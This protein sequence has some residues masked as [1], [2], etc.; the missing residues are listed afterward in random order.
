MGV[1][2]SLW[3]LGWRKYTGRSASHLMRKVVWISLAYGSLRSFPAFRFFGGK[4]IGIDFRAENELLVSRNLLPL[5][6]CFFDVC[7][8]VVE[9]I[10]HVLVKCTVANQVWMVGLP[11]L[12]EL[13]LWT[14]RGIGCLPYWEYLTFSLHQTDR[15]RGNPI[16]R[17][18]LPYYQ[19]APTGDELLLTSSFGL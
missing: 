4:L 5:S 15:Q 3:R 9:D 16:E 13:E 17:L 8:G 7:E 11:E 2:C 1:F 19:Q 10:D 12:F 14:L 6:Q 18:W